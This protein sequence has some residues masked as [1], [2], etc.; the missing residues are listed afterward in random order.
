MSPSSPVT[1][2]RERGF[3]VVVVGGMALDFC[4]TKLE[5]QNT[6][7]GYRAALARGASV[8]A[9]QRREA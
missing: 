3:H 7:A 9:V 6:A 5:A 2:R 1:V 8:A 4:A